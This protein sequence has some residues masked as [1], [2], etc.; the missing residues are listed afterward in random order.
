MEVLAEESR[1]ALRRWLDFLRTGPPEASVD[2]V[3]EEWLA[4]SGEFAYFDVL[5]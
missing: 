3:R 1:A 4:A 2:Q 5:C